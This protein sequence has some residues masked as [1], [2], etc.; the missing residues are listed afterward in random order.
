MI[1]LDVKM[2]DG[3]QFKEELCNKLNRRKQNVKRRNKKEN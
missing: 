2:S 3:T 1:T